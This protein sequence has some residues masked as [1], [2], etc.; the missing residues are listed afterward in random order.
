M[1]NKIGL[2]IAGIIIFL[3]A[4]GCSS[5]GKGIDKITG[6]GSQANSS[7]TSDGN[8]SLTDKA[9]DVSVGEE[10]I[11]IPECDDA[12]VLIAEEANSPED[13]F[14]TKA[15]KQVFLNQARKAIKDS[16]EKNKGDKTKMASTCKD[17]KTQILKFKADKDAKVK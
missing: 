1:S 8:K 6:G 15:V 14:A 13:N 16:I 2:F 3:A 9:V 12:M 7:S 11:G 17:M 10:K 5:V 4:L